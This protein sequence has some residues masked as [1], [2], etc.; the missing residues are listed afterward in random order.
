MVKRNQ[1]YNPICPEALIRQC[2]EDLL[3]GA[4]YAHLLLAQEVSRPLQSKSG[5]PRI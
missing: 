5:S 2:V 4:T 1:T 3:T